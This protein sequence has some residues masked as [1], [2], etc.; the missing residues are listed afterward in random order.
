MKASKFFAVLSIIVFILCVVSL[1]LTVFAQIPFLE[2][3]RN[4]T[5][6]FVTN[7]E[8]V[9][10]MLRKY[11]LIV[12]GISLLVCIISFI[13]IKCKSNEEVAIPELQKDVVVKKAP[14]KKEKAVVTRADASMKKAKQKRFKVRGKDTA[15]KAV[16]IATPIVTQSTHTM[17]A[18][19]FLNS[20]KK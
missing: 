2:F 6:D 17:S 13:V 14:V 20:F 11:S 4:L 8:A 10:E 15:K 1:V 7:D 16:D 3:Y 5:C 19:E 18:M 12:G 9:L